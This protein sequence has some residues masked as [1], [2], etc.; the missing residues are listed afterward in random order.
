MRHRFPSLLAILL[1]SAV[2]ASTAL[3]QTSRWHL[4]PRVSYH[5]DAEEFGIG[6]QF[7]V[8]IADRV[9]FYPSFDVFLVDAGSFTD[10][11][12]DLKFRIGR[13]SVNWL[14]VGAGLNLARRSVGPFDNNRTG[15]NLFAGAESLR[16]RVHP[17]GE[18]RIVANNRTT[19]RAAFGLN[20]TLNNHH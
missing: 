18:I 6:A 1:L 17:F 10:F 7:S 3:A 9:E 8:P 4:G 15:L 12:A 16:G 19:A 13:S 2:G 5:F 20:F 11:N 14:Y